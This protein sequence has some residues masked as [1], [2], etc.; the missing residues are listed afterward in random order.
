MNDR[1]LVGL[2]GLRGVAALLVLAY[3]AQ[4]DT[5]YESHWMVK[6]Y[7]AVDLFFILSG[8][9]IARS[10][11][12]RMLSGLRVIPY[13]KIRLIRLYPVIA[14]GVILSI[15]VELSLSRNADV[16]VLNVSS[17]LLII[18]SLWTAGSVFIFNAVQWSLF[19]ELVANFGHGLIV[20]KLSMAFLCIWIVV[21]GSALVGA[22]AFY[23]NANIGWDRAT[24]P[25]GLARVAFGF[26]AGLLLYRLW[27]R[28]SFPK[29]SLPVFLPL[30]AFVGG[31]VL[32]GHPKIF[33]RWYV[34]PLIIILA[35]PPL[36]WLTAA[37]KGGRAVSAFA[38]FIGALSYPV[39]ALHLPS[40]TLVGPIARSLG[41]SEL[42]VI[43]IKVSVA[44]LVAWAALR[45]YDEP[46]RK[47]L[48]ARM[49]GRAAGR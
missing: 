31:L 41:A 42:A 6:S 22:I 9:V 44:V 7:L 21:S 45:W 13:M 3:H 49:K 19:F 1:H 16:T 34:D 43:P 11:E 40:V 39:Y 23:G 35:L 4:L 18:P 20:R 48:T 46:V 12:A 47:F 37:A 14:A 29:L 33:W 32:T 5:P 27:V 30:A 28:D 10:Y 38:L 15:F 17:H 8:F 26:S 24:F 36:V 25:G 2:D